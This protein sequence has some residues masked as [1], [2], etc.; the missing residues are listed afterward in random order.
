MVS[1]AIGAAAGAAALLVVL[2]SVQAAN[3]SDAQSVDNRIL[4][5]DMTAP[6]LFICLEKNNVLPEHKIYCPLSPPI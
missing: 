1:L 2:G 3:M 4:D 6:L 5:E